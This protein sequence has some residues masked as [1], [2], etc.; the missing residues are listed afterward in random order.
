MK[1]E[2][3][4]LTAPLQKSE[5]VKTFDNLYKHKYVNR[6]LATIAHKN[7]IIADQLRP[8]KSQ[9]SSALNFFNESPAKKRSKSI[10]SLLP[11]LKE[12]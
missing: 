9:S 7:Q 11:K 4:S 5:D 12:L 3:P 1:V 10:G 6:S 8:E 2:L